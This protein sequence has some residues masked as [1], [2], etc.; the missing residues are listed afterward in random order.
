VK[1]TETRAKKIEQF[2]GMLERHEVIHS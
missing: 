1:R 2:V